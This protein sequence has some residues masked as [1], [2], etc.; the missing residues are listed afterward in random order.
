MIPNHYSRQKST[1]QWKTNTNVYIG[2]IQKITYEEAVSASS[3]KR[4]RQAATGR[5]IT[6]QFLECGNKKV[7]G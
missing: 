4:I 5:N 6:V 7:L 2:L 1:N 3:N